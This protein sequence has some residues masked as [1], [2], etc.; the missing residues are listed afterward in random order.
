MRCHLLAAVLGVFSLCA[1]ASA[2]DGPQSYRFAVGVDYG[3][4]HLHWGLTPR[5]ATELRWQRASSQSGDGR[6]RAEAFGLRGVRYSSEWKSWRFLGGVEGDYVAADA[7]GTTH[8]RV[9]GAGLGAFIGAEA[10]VTRRITIG[11][12]AGPY[13]L[14][15]KERTTHA[16]D[17]SVEFV[18]NSSLSVYLF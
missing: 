13:L 17:S 18:A 10:R 11:V 7:A 15:L 12:D 1:P 14:S 9:S 3:G 6:V 2:A 5:W 16:S 4:A 8:A